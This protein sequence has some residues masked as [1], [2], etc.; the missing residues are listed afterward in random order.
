MKENLCAAPWLSVYVDPTGRIDNCC[1]GKNNLGH[2]EQDHDLERVLTQGKNF[3]VQTAMLNDQRLPGCAWCHDRDHNLQK[4][5][6]SKFPD[7]D[8]A[9]YQ[10]SGQFD[11]RYLD[12]R[13]R[14][15]CNY[16]C[17][18]CTPELSSAWAE[19]LNQP[20][21]I[22]NAARRQ[23]QSYIL[24]NLHSVEEV[25]LAGGEPLLMKEHQ[26]FLEKLLE[27]RPQCQITVNTN[28]SNIKNNRIFDLLTQF[29]R[30]TWQISV[31]D[32]D[33][34]YEYIRYPG[35]WKEFW[36]NLETL[37]DR[38]NS[39][40]IGFNMVYMNLN[41]VSVWDLVD[42]LIS[43]GYSTSYMSLGL[44]N[45]GSTDGPWDVKYLPREYQ[46]QALQR[47]NDKKY[48][49]LI[50]YKNVRDYLEDPKKDAAQANSLWK[51]LLILDRRRGLDS[52]KIFPDIYKYHK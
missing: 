31:D 23:L 37:T 3:E 45:N 8:D 47:A 15:L 26:P 28:L 33:S 46:Q 34:R 14:N 12:L 11:L 6:W 2:V 4:M 21:K 18:Y 13:W 50:G 9:L 25:Y 41:A 38:A 44:Y 49:Q 36:Q 10:R 19:E 39:N 51:E 52:R 27:I 22:E 20:V 29:D 1:V 42:R 43:S 17:I 48:H 16:A 5:F 7:R 30:C 35:S 32:Q 40:I 24:D